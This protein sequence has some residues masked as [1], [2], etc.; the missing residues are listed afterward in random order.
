MA[1]DLEIN[2]K[3]VVDRIQAYMDK[4]KM[5]S[6]E[7]CEKAGIDPA[8]FS[9]YRTLKY[10]SLATENYF[11]I[12]RAMFMSAEELLYGAIST[13]NVRGIDNDEKGLIRDYRMLD[14]DDKKLVL[15]VTQRLKEGNVFA[16]IEN[17][18]TD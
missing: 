1:D 16:R 4:H 6:R 11:R 15:K 7:L 12:A 14:A 3:E 5:T 17:M 8:T 2:Q 18:T 13:P 9:R 10:K